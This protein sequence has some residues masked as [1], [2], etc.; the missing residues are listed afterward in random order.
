[1]ILMF[2]KDP[3]NVSRPGICICIQ[4]VKCYNG[5]MLLNNM[6]WVGGLSASYFLLT[7]CHLCPLLTSVAINNSTRMGQMSP[8]SV[9]HTANKAEWLCTRMSYLAKW[10]LERL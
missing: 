1:M 9:A 3:L 10:C 7:L 5:L 4:S 8:T 2:Y 6:Q